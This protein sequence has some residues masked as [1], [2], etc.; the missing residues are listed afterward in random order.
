MPRLR[1]QVAAFTATRI[2]L[3]TMHRMV[4]PFL[5]AFSRSLGVDIEAL[6]LAVTVRS[7]GGALGPVLASV[8]D[9]R[10]RKAGML[11]GLLLFV[12]GVGL[13]WIWPAYPA[14]LVALM[15][16]MLGKYVFDPAMQAYLGDRI[17]YER[18][19]RVLAITE[20]GW[21]L[22]FILG[23]PA[24]GLL[25]AR[26][27]WAAP[28]P[29]LA[30][31]GL[32]A[33]GVLAWSL[34][35]DPERHAGQPNL[36]ANLRRVAAHPAALTGLAMG[37]LLSSA[38]EVVNLVFGVW[39]EDSFGL[40]VAALGAASAVIGLS[41]LGGETLTAAITD[42]LGK[43]LAVGLGLGLNSLTALALPFLGSSLAGALVGL[44]L[45]YITFEYT[46]VSSIPLMTEVLPSARATLMA[47]NAAGL[48]L[49]RA[50]GALMSTP[51]YLYGKN[52]PGLPDVLPVALASI[53]FNLLALFALRRL[54]QR[55]KGRSGASVI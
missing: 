55:N 5:P 48:S 2:V 12:L 38:N 34:P 51:L 3:N 17:S 25:I 43:P 44:F 45:F 4:Y 29:F 31:L 50:V 37:L 9:S 7:L 53:G 1:Y 18:R 6:S 10:G 23:V 16:A 39:L 13:V 11:F 41:E 33:F 22:S 14:F 8:S 27:G 21:S 47:A 19:G 32:V 20:L 52:L 30:L 40:Q 46:L 24:A 36:W 54:Q 35:P 28:F 15:L 26:R 49:G 42:R